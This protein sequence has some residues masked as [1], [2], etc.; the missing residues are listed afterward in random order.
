[1]ILLAF[2]GVTLEIPRKTNK[3][4]R[5]CVGVCLLTPRAD[6]GCGKLAKLRLGEN[7]TAGRSTWMLTIV[8]GSSSQRRSANG[9]R[10]GL[11]KM[12]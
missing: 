8:F 11:S 7:R 4:L 6:G 9:M 1:M 2:Q 10:R 5:S 12:V 3:N